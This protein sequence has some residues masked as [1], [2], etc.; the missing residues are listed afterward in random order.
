MCFS[1]P[2]RPTFYHLSLELF[3][4]T[5]PKVSPNHTLLLHSVLSQLLSG[6]DI[7]FC[8]LTY[9]CLSPSRGIHTVLVLLNAV[10]SVHRTRSGNSRVLNKGLPNERMNEFNSYSHAVKQVF[11]LLLIYKQ[12]WKKKDCWRLLTV[13][14]NSSRGGIQTQTRL[15]QWWNCRA[16]CPDNQENVL[17]S[18]KIYMLLVASYRIAQFLVKKKKRKFIIPHKNRTTIVLI[19]RWFNAN[20]K[21]TSSFSFF[22]SYWH[23]GFV[24]MSTCQIWNH[25]CSGI[26]C[27]REKS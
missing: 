2:W 20:I 10:Y 3:L 15:T 17:I 19:F 24:H 16:D 14:F 27:R 4:F 6:T 11:Y 22:L 12:M 5:Q 1:G 9:Y 8:I 7:L 13:M 25:I 26:V 21:E 18:R 23:M